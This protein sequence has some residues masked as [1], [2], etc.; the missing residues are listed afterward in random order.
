MSHAPQVAMYH[1]SATVLRSGV[2][3]L[4]AF[5]TL[6]D[7]FATQAILPSLAIRYQVSPAAMGLAVNASTLGMAIAG[8]AV[9]F[10]SR[11]IDRRRGILVSLALLSIPTALLATAPNLATFA[12]LRIVQGCFMVSA[13]SLT[14]A[15]LGE[16]CSAEDAGGA[17]AAYIAGNVAS[18]LFGRLV[19]AAVAETYGLSSNFY[20]FAALNL[21]G[22]ALV[23]FTVSR[24][25]PVAAHTMPELPPQAAW[26]RHLENP[27]LRASFAGG[28]CILFAFIGTFTFVNFVLVRPPF[29][30]GMM[31]LGLVYFVF[32]PSLVTTLFTGRAVAWLGTQATVIGAMAIAGAGLLMLLSGS[33][34]VLLIGLALV[35]IG[36]FAAQAAATG[37]VGRAAKTDRS[38]A[39]GLYLASY[40]LGGLVGTAVLGQVFDRFGWPACVAGIALALALV[41]LLAIRMQLPADRRLPSMAA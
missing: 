19:S 36:T 23:Y 35:A 2:I 11:R 13:F 40:F 15:H 28:F 27:A 5:L 14:L 34:P 24:T 37:F 1:R 38:T 7:L 30:I 31:S 25:P 12:A 29:G 8:F 39:S 26:R 20:F 4:T 18:N 21:A 22:A 16:R 32:A 10:L 3:A 17:F 9:A 33:L 6:V 41:A